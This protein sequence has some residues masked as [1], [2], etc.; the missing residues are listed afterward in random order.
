M[1]RSVGRVFRISNHIA[2]KRPHR[3]NDEAFAAENH[4]Y[5][6]LARETQCP[7]LVPSYFRTSKANFIQFLGGE[8]LETRIRRH[9]VREPTTKQVVRVS[10]NEPL[11]LVLR[12]T[13]ELTDA[14]AVLEERGYVHA[15][16]RP[17]NMVLDDEDHL[18]LIDFDCAT[19]TGTPIEGAQP[20]YARVQGDKAG[21]EERGSFG[22][23]GPRT[24]QF[25][26]DS[27]IYLLTRGF[28]LYD[29]WFGP[30]H[31][32]R[33]VTLLQEMK[34]PPTTDDAIDSIIRRCWTGRYGSIRALHKDVFLLAQVADVRVASPMRAEE[35]E[36]RRRECEVLVSQG[37][38]DLVPLG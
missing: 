1:W 3:A 16:L 23:H 38:L 34:F 28:E 5:D 26:I 33:V 27:I 15:D 17:P 37:I 7:N 10:Y 32:P 36:T 22:D 30:D 18:K 2:L 8:N 29:E 4:F 9:Q 21:E 13:L 31:G 25:A 14:V 12:W 20:P 35:R 19:L 11:A 24:E 6:I